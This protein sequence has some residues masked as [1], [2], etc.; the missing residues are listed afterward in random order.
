[1]LYVSPLILS[2]KRPIQEKIKLCGFGPE[3]DNI[4][5]GGPEHDNNN[6]YPHWKNG[7]QVN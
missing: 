7:N 4:L 5:L 1:M 3:A 2:N 6:T